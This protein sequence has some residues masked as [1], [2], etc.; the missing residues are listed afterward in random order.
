[1]LRFIYCGGQKFFRPPSK[2]TKIILSGLHVYQICSKFQGIF[3][4]LWFH[5]FQKIT[6]FDYCLEFI[7]FFQKDGGAPK[8]LA[9]ISFAIEIDLVI[10]LKSAFI[11]FWI[12]LGFG[13]LIFQKVAKIILWLLSAYF[14]E[15]WL[16]FPINRVNN[17]NILLKIPHI[18]FKK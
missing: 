5:I 11:F 7:E 10:F 12:Y 16:H 3:F 6:C 13:N 18:N 17:F 15:I 4:G 2:N 1:M 9:T 14:F 8:L